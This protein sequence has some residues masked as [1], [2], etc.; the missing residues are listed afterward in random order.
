MY[1]VGA[2]TMAQVYKRRDREKQLGDFI[3]GEDRGGDRGER[4]ISERGQ[5]VDFHSGWS[6]RVQPSQIEYVAAR[7]GLALVAQL[8]GDLK[9]M[10]LLMIDGADLIECADET[11]MPLKDAMRLQKNVQA[12]IHR[13]TDNSA[14]DPTN[15]D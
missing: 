14:P 6:G 2:R 3:S 10:A 5:T 4:D 1:A 13:L 7:E 15:S 12:T 11:H 8:P 9:Q